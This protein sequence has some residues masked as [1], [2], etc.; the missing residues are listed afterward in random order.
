MRLVQVQPRDPYAP[1]RCDTLL[2]FSR[3][4]DGGSV[5]L[6]TRRHG[7]W[8]VGLVWRPRYRLW[9][10]HGPEDHRR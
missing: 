10:T 6:R 4:P 2:T 5:T 1:E 3:A 8:I 7:A 9:W